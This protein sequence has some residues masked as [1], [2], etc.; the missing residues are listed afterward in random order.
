M[1]SKSDWIEKT[2]SNL[3]K[4]DESETEKLNERELKDLTE[5]AR[6]AITRRV[7]YYAPLVGVTYNRISIRHQ[8]TRWGSCSKQGNLNFNCLLVLMPPEV[9]DS[10]VVHELCHRLEMNH[11]KAFYDHV[12]RVYP[13]YKKWHKWLNEH[14][15]KYLDM[16]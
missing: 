5:A 4:A 1:D 8:H 13:D 3:P 12:L 15:R 2:L 14:G 10:I 6:K 16:I 11:S 9:L 7:E